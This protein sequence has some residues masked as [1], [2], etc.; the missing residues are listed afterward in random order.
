MIRVQLDIDSV[1][2]TGVSHADAAVVL[3]TLRQD[4]AAA[5]AP[6]AARSALVRGGSR[7]V[8]TAPTVAPSP[9]PQALGRAAA[10]AVTRGVLP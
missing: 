7:Q 1:H 4:L 9:T 3:A 2:L 5:L 8:A 10:G 6:E